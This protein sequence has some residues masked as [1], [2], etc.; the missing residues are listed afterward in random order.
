SHPRRTTC[1]SRRGESPPNP[2]RA[3]PCGTPSTAPSCRPP[4]SRSAERS[5]GAPERH[6]SSVGSA[7]AA[8][9]DQRDTAARCPRPAD[10]DCLDA[11]P[12]RDRPY[13]VFPRPQEVVRPRGRPLSYGSRKNRSESP[14]S[15]DREPPPRCRR[16]ALRCRPDAVLDL[17]RTRTKRC[18]RPP[19]THPARLSHCDTN[20]PSWRDQQRRDAS[21]TTW[22]GDAYR[23]RPRRLSAGNHTPRRAGSPIARKPGM[24]RTARSMATSLTKSAPQLVPREGTLSGLVEGARASEVAHAER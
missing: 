12:P 17:R 8:P 7:R 10:T 15:P 18:R 24:P 1:P 16:L 23:G 2:A 13:P 14:C 22:S 4:A 11:P 6:P 21:V 5:D 20:M 3:P 19:A 9:P